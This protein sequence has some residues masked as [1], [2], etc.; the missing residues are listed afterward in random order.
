MDDIDYGELDPGVRRTVRWLRSLGYETCD[1]GDGV[2]K[3]PDGWMVRDYP[4][5]TMRVYASDLVALADDMHVRLE[6]AGF[7]VAPVG[8]HVMNRDGEVVPC[9]YIQANY[10]PANGI[11]FLEVAGL[12]D[13]LLPPE[14]MP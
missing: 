6:V 10:D 5:V 2:T 8:G 7:K 9:V 4:H 12:H 14:F 1:S 13:G 11:G 3:K